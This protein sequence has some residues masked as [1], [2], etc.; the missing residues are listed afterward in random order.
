MHILL[1]VFSDAF[2]GITP[3][4]AANIGMAF[5]GDVND[6][7]KQQVIRLPIVVRLVSS[8]TVE[9]WQPQATADLSGQPFTFNSAGFARI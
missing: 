7:R 1:R 4:R 2:F 8:D 3:W 6:S 5:F 9:Q